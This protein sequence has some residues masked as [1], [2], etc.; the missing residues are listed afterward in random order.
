M[1]AQTDTITTQAS[2]R[3]F[4][5]FKITRKRSVAL[6]LI[7]IGIYI[8]LQGNA[9]LDSSTRSILTFE[10]G[11]I[12]EVAHIVVH[13]LT[14][15]TIAGVF[16]IISGVVALIEIPELR[17]VSMGLLIICGI[18][19]TPVLL[20]A[21]S[22]DDRTNAT[23]MLTE[24]LRLATPIAIG[25][26]AGI[27]C[28]RSGVINIAIEGMMLF[29]AGFGFTA[30]Y[31]LRG[32]VPDNTALFIAVL[33]AVGIG[34][35]A[36]LLHAWLSITFRTDQIISG[37][38][39]NIMA[40]GVTSFVRREYLAATEA[41]SITLPRIAL[42]VLKDIPILGDTLFS[43]QPIFYLMFVIIILTQVMLFYTRWGLR[44]RAVGEHPSAADTLGINVNRTRWTN[45]FVAGLIA[46]LAGAWFSLEATGR[47]ND[48]MTSGAGFIALAAMIFGKWTPFGAFGAA[49]LFGFSDA[50][51]TRFQIEDVALPSQFLQ[52]VPYVVTIVVL[53]GFIGHAFPPKASGKPYVKEGH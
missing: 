35:I 23:T 7:L 4:S 2:S 29:A 45:V 13:T 30:L 43:S 22:A 1:T 49:L 50:L 19:L 28:E 26:M 38:V 42:P 27:W 12:D 47:F 44:V 6:A 34:G 46:G 16:F 48:N 36:S 10:G 41:G 24:S 37:T 18:L 3:S 5:L 14:V 51:G 17:R 25:A 53:A 33:V 40:V 9:H 21:A 39:I 8:L 11:D 15:L 32:T 20:I 31:F 52:M